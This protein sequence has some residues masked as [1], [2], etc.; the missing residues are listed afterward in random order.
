[1]PDVAEEGQTLTEAESPEISEKL[2]DEAFLPTEAVEPPP[3]AEE[4]EEPAPEPTLTDPAAT[5]SEGHA[6]SQE[7]V[8]GN[9][10]GDPVDEDAPP[11]HEPYCN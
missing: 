8:A 7:P 6:N 3:P 10:S 1:M 9:I 4:L 2:D 11:S 5:E